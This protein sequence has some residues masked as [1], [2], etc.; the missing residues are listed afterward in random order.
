MAKENFLPATGTR[1]IDPAAAE[2]RDNAADIIISNYKKYGF[3]SIETPSLEKIENLTG[4][5]GGE[6]EKLIFKILKR[7]KELEEVLKKGGSEENVLADFGL[8]YDLTV[9]LARYYA[10]YKD[11]LPKPFKVFQIGNVWRAERPQKS[12]YRQFTQ[13]DIDIIGDPSPNCEIE[14]IYV[15][16]KTLRELKIKNFEVRI[17]DRQILK[18]IGAD[19]GVEGEERY[20]DFL[21]ALDKLD[22]K[23]PEEIIEELREKKFDEPVLV[24]IKNK[25]ESLKNGSENID[26]ASG[27][28]DPD[29][30]YAKS[31][32][33]LSFII[34]SVK[35][36]FGDINIRFDPLLVR[37]M[38]YYTGTI[39]EVNEINGSI[40]FGGGG[41]YNNM[42]GLFSGQNVS[43]CGFSLGFER[44]ID[45]FFSGDKAKNIKAA[46]KAALMYSSKDDDYPEV[47]AYCE[48]LRNKFPV[49]SVFDRQKNLSSQLDKLKKIGFTH[50]GFYKG[51]QT[52][53]SEMK[54][55]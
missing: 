42:I 26:I 11:N 6:N 12:R 52:Q 37:G 2:I 32:K 30:I 23:T 45:A 53:I 4:K 33:N 3:N 25:F 10:H 39:Y 50:W 54:N 19:C 27:M 7:G 31:C 22:K 51:S 46:Q 20:R 21:I 35:S 5:K 38:D 44:I 40:S 47:L 15:T 29:E 48:R 28:K 55:G 41:R 13:C 16:C 36:L 43:A 1:D 8:R 34:S 49:V 18:K 24:G 9:P 17:N 14:L